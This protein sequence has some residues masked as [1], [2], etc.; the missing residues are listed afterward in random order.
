M[1]ALLSIGE[2]SRLTHLSV[3]ALRHYDDVGLLAPIHV[4]P[5]TGYR[6]Y[7]SAQ[8]P[9]AQLIRRFREMDMPIEQVRA[10]LDAPDLGTRDETIVAHLQ[11]M[12][13]SLERTQATVASLEALLEGRAASLPV[14]FRT[15]PRVPVLAISGEVTW[16][17]A[18]GW[19][20]EAFTELRA[21]LDAAPSARAGVDSALFSEEFFEAHVGEVTAYA[22]LDGDVRASGRSTRTEVPA[23]DVAVTVHHGTANN[24]DRAYGALGTFVAERKLGGSGPIREHFLVGPFDTDDEDQLRTEVC[25]P[26]RPGAC[27]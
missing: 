11:R 21:T 5:A 26:L 6:H 2:F 4:D 8:V 16:D 17:E 14:E 19:L 3:K 25:W 24:I 27:N 9:T 12:Q 7:A 20:G 13:Q 15:E 18:L 10:V 22:E 1:S 23:A